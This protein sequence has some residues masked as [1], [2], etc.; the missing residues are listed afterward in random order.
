MKDD[1]G[2][3]EL[4]V[5]GRP[6]DPGI[7]VYVGEWAAEFGDNDPGM[8]LETVQHWAWSSHLEPGEVHNAMKQARHEA[9]K[10]RGRLVQPMAWAMTALHTALSERC[11]ARGMPPLPGSTTPIDERAARLN[12]AERVRRDLAQFGDV[13]QLTDRQQRAYDNL[14]AELVRLEAQLE[15]AEVSA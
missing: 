15:P 3:D 4:L 14:A 11:V 6:V 7:A 8:T 9:R 1:D 5:D 2:G 13:D 10:R 12:H